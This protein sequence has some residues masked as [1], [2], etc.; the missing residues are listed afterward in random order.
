MQ[1]ANSERTAVTPNLPI[2]AACKKSMGAAVL[3]EQNVSVRAPPVSVSPR[4]RFSRCV[5]SSPPVALHCV[6]ANGLGRLRHVRARQISAGF[7][8]LAA[9]FLFA[10]FCERTCAQ[11]PIRQVPR[12]QGSGFGVQGSGTAAQ[13]PAVRSLL[14]GNPQSASRNPQAPALPAVARVV[15]PERD[16]V[17]YGSG[18]LIDAR[19]QFGLVISNWHVVRDAAGPITV[20]FPDGFKSPAEVVKTDK[21]W[22]LAALSIYR[23][24]V[25]PIPI[26][27]AAP[28]PGDSLTIAG[29]GSG[30]WR[31]ASG[32]C[33]QYL[34]PGV[35]FPHEM[36]ELA[37]EARQGDSG[38]PILNQRGELAGVLFGSGPGYTSGSYGGRVLQF[39]AAVVPGGAP[40]NDGVAPDARLPGREDGRRP[41]EGVASQSPRDGFPPAGNIDV[42]ASGVPQAT[43]LHDNRLPASGSDA[44]TPVQ[45]AKND[46]LLSPPPRTEVAGRFGAGGPAPSLDDIDPR[47]AVAP[48]RNDF[49]SPAF[50]A[51]S[52]PAASAPFQP[53]L[54]PR[55][56]SS[57]ADEAATGADTKLLAMIWQR[58]GGPTLFDQAKAVFAIIGALALVVVFLR[59]GSSK[60]PEHHEE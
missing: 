4:W 36:V 53:S 33:T 46:P 5:V 28:Q 17:S 25:T 49:I 6:C 16:G 8:G 32:R 13:Q 39:L 35:E 22:D 59:F 21:D 1:A 40:G 9:S 20:E 11:F 58:F 14:T 31:M 45:R 37:A 2:A 57:P 48:S 60:E 23:P 47:V 3:R 44:L 42:P 54:A 12:S 55:S 56:G 41:G 7:L 10:T 27:A 30:D 24:R 26:T 29:Y 52:T 50:S 18:T 19:G 38:G 15:V 51:S 34:A 43:A